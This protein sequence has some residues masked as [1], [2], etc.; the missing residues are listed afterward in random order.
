MTVIDTP[1]LQAAIGDPSWV[2][3]PISEVKD[4]KHALIVAMDGMVLG[5][6]DGT[7]RVKAESVAAMTA[8]LQGAARSASNKAHDLPKGTLVDSVVTTSAAGTY[9]VMPAGANALVV[10][11]GGPDMPM[12][13]AA[14]AVT[15]QANKLGEK[16][17][18]VGVRTDVGTAS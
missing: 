14:Q 18:S 4:V 1:A 15:K 7:D 16:L 12:G 9:M 3:K 2:L 17:M 13:V 5:A 6:S 8:A 11:V 10:V